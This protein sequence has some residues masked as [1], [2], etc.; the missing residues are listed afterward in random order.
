MTKLTGINDRKCALLQRLATE[1][2]VAIGACKRVS[3]RQTDQQQLS[4]GGGQ[5][6][7]RACQPRANQNCTIL[8]LHVVQTSAG[9]RVQ[10]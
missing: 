10:I 1:K 3:L 6:V 5:N 8:T 7:K 4:E 9:D 2:L